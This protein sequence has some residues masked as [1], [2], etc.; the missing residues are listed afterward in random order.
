MSP[1]RKCGAGRLR[2]GWSNLHVLT[3][4]PDRFN[5]VEAAFVDGIGSIAHLRW[6]PHGI[7]ASCREN[8]S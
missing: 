5:D 2:Y 6:T 7:V 1:S 4:Q 3:H 8:G